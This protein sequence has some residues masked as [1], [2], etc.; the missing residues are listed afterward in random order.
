MTE[1]NKGDLPPQIVKK[2]DGFYLKGTVNGREQEVPVDKAVNWMQMGIHSSERNAEIKAKESELKANETRYAE[3]EKIRDAIDAHPEVKADFARYLQTSGIMGG[4]PKPVLQEQTSRQDADDSD[5][6]ETPPARKGP[7]PEILELKQTV[8]ALKQDA[9]ARGAHDQQTKL[10]KI[11]DGEIAAYPHL[12]GNTKAA[13]LAREHIMARIASNPEAARDISALV[14][15][16]A[17]S[18]KDIMATQD[19]E[20]RKRQAERDVLSVETSRGATPSPAAEKLLRETKPGDQ[21][22]HRLMRDEVLQE[23]LKELAGG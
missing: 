18:L 7:D 4:A 17:N 16:E 12:K 19:D 22:G 15:T 11:I 23:A 9:M 8:E 20:L 5:G 21:P 6:Q 3:F 13:G 2:D 14:L 1:E 10:G